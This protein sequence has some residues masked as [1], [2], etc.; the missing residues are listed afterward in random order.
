MAE[1][2]DFFVAEVGASAALVGLIAVGLSIS[3]SE[4]I[5]FPHLL[6]RA[7]GSLVLLLAVLVTSTMLLAPGQ[8][9]HTAGIELV[10]AGAVAWIVTTAL[11][12]RGLRSVPLPY[13]ENQWMAI[14][15][16]Q[17]ATIPV[18]V[19]GVAALARGAGGLYWL[20]PGFVAAY[21][22]ALFDAWVILVEVHR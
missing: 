19:A 2:H 7:A 3:L 17:V 4:L 16:R 14:G 9:V 21:V 10:L 13:R 5:R 15:M 20:V 1:W 11:G 8:T 18:V 6:L 12:F 22:V